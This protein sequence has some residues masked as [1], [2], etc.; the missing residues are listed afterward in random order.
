MLRN[1]TTAELANSVEPVDATKGTTADESHRVGD[2]AERLNR[3]R[4]EL[5]Y[6]ASDLNA[7]SRRADP[8]RAAEMLALSDL[9]AAFAARWR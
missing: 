1:E 4:A 8:A 5:L 9:I 7:G 6:L 2:A 3:V